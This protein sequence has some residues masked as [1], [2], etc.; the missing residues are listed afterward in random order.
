MKL[1]KGVLIG[2]VIGI[3]APVVL[4]VPTQAIEINQIQ[5]GCL[6]IGFAKCLSGMQSDIS[7]LMPIELYDKFKRKNQEICTQLHSSLTNRNTGGRHLR[8]EVLS[9]G[10]L[11]CRLN[12]ELGLIMELEALG[13]FH[14]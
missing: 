7:Y 1:I 4:T 10:I 13:Y 8:G 2:G 11:R 12:L 3:A 5:Q 6:R 14:N 9:Q